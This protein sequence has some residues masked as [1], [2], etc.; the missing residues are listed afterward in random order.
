MD[1]T[2]IYYFKE[3]SKTLNMTQTAKELFISQQTLSNRII[4]LEKECGVKLF[5]R[6]P[7]LILTDAGKSMVHFSNKILNEKINL[8][9]IF[10]ELKNENKGTINFGASSLRMNASLPKIIPHFYKIFPKVKIQL[11]DGISKQLEPLIESG[12]LDLAI[13]AS[14]RDNINFNKKHLMNDQLFICIP[15]DLLIKYYGKSILCKRNDFVKGVSV[16]E[17]RDLP[18]LE[19]DNRIGRQIQSCFEEANF[20]P[21]IYAKG[22]YI[23]IITGIGLSGVAAFFN[24]RLSL[25]SR[26]N[27][28][29]KNM[30]IFP[31]ILNGKPIFQKISLISN[32]DRYYPKYLIAFSKMLINFFENVE[33]EKVA[34]IAK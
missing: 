25:I 30:N 29:P 21:E 1:F 31:L 4:K 15:N 22:S 9:Y 26:K 8:D 12:D 19:L 3:L 11:V 33:N 20:M 34:R 23:Q 6:K 10:S 24:T 14:N 7:K 18:F 32:K 27:E 13:V 28:I 16:S 17:F 2:S 5:Y